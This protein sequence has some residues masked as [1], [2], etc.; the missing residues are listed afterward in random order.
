M[1]NAKGDLSNELIERVYQS[2][3]A[4]QQDLLD[5]LAIALE[6]EIKRRHTGKAPI[7]FGRKHAFEIIAK[8]GIW[9]VQ[10]NLYLNGCNQYSTE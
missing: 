3:P 10:N 4:D 1:V 7:M 2:L 6:T 5:D 8:L 9:L